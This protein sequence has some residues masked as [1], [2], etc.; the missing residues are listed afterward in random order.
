MVYI[1]DACS[2]LQGQHEEVTTEQTSSKSSSAR[3]SKEL[4]L[5]HQSNQKISSEC[6]DSLG[7]NTSGIQKIV[8]VNFDVSTFFFLFFL[9]FKGL[10][11][12]VLL[13]FTECFSLW[14][15]NQLTNV[16]VQEN[17]DYWFG[18]DPE[19]SITDLWGK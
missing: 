19:V 16:G 3:D 1:I 13:L 7:S 15:P 17:D 9:I 5:D 2:K 10:D 14:K 6:L 11:V 8:P 12:Q 18:S 4:S